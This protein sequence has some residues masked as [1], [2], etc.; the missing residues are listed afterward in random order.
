[1]LHLGSHLKK[2]IR[3]PKPM[4][5]ITCTAAVSAEDVVTIHDR[6]RCYRWELSD[7]LVPLADKRHHSIACLEDPCSASPK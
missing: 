4:K 6:C 5:I 2:V 1:M 7:R 3:K